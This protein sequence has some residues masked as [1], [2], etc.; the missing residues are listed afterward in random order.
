MV[1]KQFHKA[2]DP[3]KSSSTAEGSASLANCLHASHADACQNVAETGIVLSVLLNVLTTTSSMTMSSRVHLLIV[4]A[5]VFVSVFVKSDG[6]YTYEI[7][8]LLVAALS[9]TPFCPSVILSIS[10]TSALL[11]NVQ[12]GHIQC[13]QEKVALMHI[14]ITSA[15]THRFKQML[16]TRG[17]DYLRKH[18]GSQKYIVS[19]VQL[20]KFK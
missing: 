8:T 11:L 17:D 1:A 4:F 10:D 9:C 18:A 20:W 16:C 2:H 5:V 6:L 12:D 7:V 13:V 3:T 14:A 19:F 15:N